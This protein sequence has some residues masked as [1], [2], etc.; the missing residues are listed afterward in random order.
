MREAAA[1]I[2]WFTS[3]ISAPPE[4]AAETPVYYAS[5]SAV[6]GMTGMFF[7]GRQAIDSSP[8]SKDQAVQK[9]LWEVS[10]ALTHVE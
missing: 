1:P 7:K 9:R 6:E 4:K 2:R 8:Y 3:L 5:S 10:A